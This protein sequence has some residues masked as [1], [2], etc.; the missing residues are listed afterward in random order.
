MEEDLTELY[1]RFHNLQFEMQDQA[2]CFWAISN[3]L[4]G[5]PSNPY[6][7]SIL[8]H[9]L[10]IRDDPVTRYIPTSQYMSRLNPFNFHFSKISDII[11]DI[12]NGI[13]KFHS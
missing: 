8:Q 2:D 10:L 13:V 9:L 7:T 11:F 12:F 6:F 3:I 5:S 1:G 4:E